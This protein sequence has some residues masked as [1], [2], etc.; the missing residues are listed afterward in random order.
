M[1][2]LSFLNTAQVETP[3]NVRV[4]SGGVGGAKKPWN[5]P[6]TLLAIRVW[7]SG[8]VYPS[9]AL[10]D[11][12][13][14]EYRKAKITKGDEVAYTPEALEKFHQGEAEA[15][16]KRNQEI[17]QA[18]ADGKEAP[19]PYVAK[20]EAP[21]KYKVSTYEY[22]GE[23]AGNGFDVID[24]R[25]WAGYKGDGHMLFIAPVAKDEPK[26]D[27]FGSTKYEPLKD[28]EVGGQIFQ[29][30][31]SGV[32]EQGS[33]TYGKSTLIKSI[34]ELYGIKLGKDKEYVDMII[35][36]EFNGLNLVKHFAQP[37]SLIPKI[38][39][40]GKEKGEAD[41]QRRENLQIWGFAPA[42]VL[43]VAVQEEAAP[44]TQLGDSKES[45]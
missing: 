31:V 32:Y 19:A 43:N 38:V 33:K 34:E 39:D 1:S 9:Q 27:L 26:V 40:R 15:V 4:H 30:P 2:L 36:D 20:T 5:P 7:E 18:I 14:L 41:Y 45:E 21:K 44:N 13:N 10:I 28:G 22:E 12:F 23:V 42:E 3:K 37:V 17:A 24:S 6:A 29:A 35:F 8:A 16:A 25:K 11:R